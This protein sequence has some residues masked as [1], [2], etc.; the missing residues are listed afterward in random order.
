[1]YVTRRRKKQLPIGPLQIFDERVDW[2]NEIKYLGIVIDK[3]LTFKAHI[4]YV[5]KRAN[6][7]IRVLYPLLSRKSKLNTHKQ[8]PYLQVSYSSNLDIWLSSYKRNR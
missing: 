7:A 3:K 5:I 4:E 1:M 6:N 8:T 2:S